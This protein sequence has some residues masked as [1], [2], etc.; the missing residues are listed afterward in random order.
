MGWSSPVTALVT[1]LAVAAMC[2]AVLL[3]QGRA[4]GARDAVV[5]TL[6]DAGSRTIV[7]RAESEAG[8]TTA[9]LERIARI[10]GVSWFGSFGQATDVTAVDGSAKVPARAWWGGSPDA[11]DL[12]AD[13]PLPGEDAYASTSAL[14]QLGLLDG[15]GE[16]RTTE[17]IG[18]GV[19]GAFNPP[20]QLR[21][22]EPLLLIPQTPHGTE[23]VRLLVIVAAT[24]AQVEP[25]ATTVAG[26]L[27]ATDPQAVSIAVSEELAGLQSSVNARLSGFTTVLVAGILLLTGVL[28]AVLQLGLVMIRRKDFGRRRALGASQGLVMALL[29]VQTTLLSAVGALVGI[30]IAVVVLLLAEDPVAGPAYVGAVGIL[31]I[32]TAVLGTLLPAVV[33]ARRDPLYELRVP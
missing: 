3:T 14:D 22:F 9:V 2:L 28:V 18:Y 8:L 4:V 20:P 26:T 16:V 25:V 31:A 19:A 13:T 30:L 7:V 1:V 15:Y 12:P 6:D 5:S 29:L 11:L 10:D 17:G 32:V 33:A 23:E 21:A 24:P 27:A